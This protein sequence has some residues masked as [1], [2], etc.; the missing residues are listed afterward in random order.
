M[1]ARRAP[2]SDVQLA[3]I[4][5][6]LLAGVLAFGAVTYVQ[7]RRGWTPPPDASTAAMLARVAP[8]VLVIAL[9]AALLIRT[10]LAGADDARRR[11][12]LIIGWAIAEGAAL[13]GGVHY[14]LSDD[15][16]WYTLGVCAMVASFVVLP[17]RRT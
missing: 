15:P 2:A 4:R 7:H 9:A 11:Q 10:R 14:F 16:R 6:A 8:I 1:T 5:M 12:L 17:V 13:L 3:I